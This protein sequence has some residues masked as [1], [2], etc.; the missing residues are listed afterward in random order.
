MVKT[1][2]LIM[3]NLQTPKN[4][5]TVSL[6]TNEQNEFFAQ[7]HKR[8]LAKSFEDVPILA[9]K[10][11]NHKDYSKPA[12]V[13]LS[14]E[15]DENSDF[16]P[17][18]V[19]VSENADLSN[20]II[21]YT[22]EKS[23]ELYNLCIGRKYYW[24]VQKNAYT[25]EIHSFETAPL[26][27]RF[28]KMDGVTNVRDLGGYKVPGGRVRQKM[29]YRGAELKYITDEGIKTFITELGIKN[30]V[31]LRFEHCHE[32]DHSNLEPYG[33][34]LRKCPIYACGGCF[35]DPAKPAI[36]ELFELLADE[37][38]Y[39][40]YF[41]C[42]AGADRTGTI[43]FM[44]ETLLGMY[45]KDIRDDYEIT[46]MSASGIRLRTDDGVIQG[47]ACLE[48]LCNGQT[49]QEICMDY[50]TRLIGI[51]EATLQK[52]RDILIEKI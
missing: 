23:S 10:E 37:A 4:N 25:S 22:N 9:E 18:K 31:E 15:D 36:R 7:R 13:Y 40:I 49:W 39:P 27:P 26:T 52:I 28:I 17:Y 20:P 33:I 45:Y 34:P 16:S 5:E 46:S 43:A 41:H 6:R 51:P 11:L 21:K 2:R 38:N 8:F 35:S 12:P 32:E 1:E 29:L 47:L 50:F 24:T 42:A 48:E 14:W 19:T 3:I 30:E 44:I